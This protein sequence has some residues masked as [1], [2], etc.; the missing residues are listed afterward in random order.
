VIKSRRMRWAGHAARKV[1]ER[2]YYSILVGQ[3][4]GKR[5]LLSCNRKWEDNIE[6]DLK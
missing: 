2:N 1:E 5:L 6:V 3:P 4:E